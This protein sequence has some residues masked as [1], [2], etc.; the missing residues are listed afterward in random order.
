MYLLVSKFRI[1]EI[2]FTIEPGRCLLQ[3]VT[4]NC[5]ILLLFF[6]H[7]GDRIEIMFLED[8][9][10][11]VLWVDF[12]WESPPWGEKFPGGGNRPALILFWGDL[13]ELLCVL[14]VILVNFR[15]LFLPTQFYMWKCSRKL[16]GSYFPCILISKKK[17]KYL[18][19]GASPE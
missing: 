6:L 2:R 19:K 13:T 9:D 10:D 15:T 5:L 16:S 8:R 18:R 17:K 3:F 4:T 14:S 1:L 7:R 11:F 12:P